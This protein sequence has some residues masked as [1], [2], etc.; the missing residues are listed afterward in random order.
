MT[1]FD[2]NSNLLDLDDTS[3]EEMVDLLLG[4]GRYEMH[5]LRVF[6]VPTGSW[7]TFAG[8]PQDILFHRL[9]LEELNFTHGPAMELEPTRSGFYGCGRLRSMSLQPEVLEC[10]R[11]YIRHQADLLPLR[12]RLICG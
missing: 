9:V 10:L 12:T 2:V 7:I 6:H 3:P 11:T 5:V 1:T 4:E 8:P